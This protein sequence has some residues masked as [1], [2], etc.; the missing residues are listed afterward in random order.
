VHAAGESSPGD[1]SP[2][3]YA[4]V[5]GIENERLLRRLA[6]NLEALKVPIHRVEESHGEYGGQLMA[7]GLEPGPK[8]VRGKY[9]SNIPLVSMGSFLEF[10]QR[11]EELIK[12]K[13][14]IHQQRVDKIQKEVREKYVPVRPSIWKTLHE[15]WTKWRKVNA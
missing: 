1:L 4:V 11:Q 3:T 8:S 6:R 13:R 5:V 12:D 2:G 9:L 7:I 15:V 14:R 10:T